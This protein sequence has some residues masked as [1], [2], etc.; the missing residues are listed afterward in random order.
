MINYW[1]PFKLGNAAI[2]NNGLPISLDELMT[3]RIGRC[4]IKLLFKLGFIH[5]NESSAENKL[6]GCT[7]DIISMEIDMDSPTIINPDDANVM[8]VVE[9]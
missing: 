4:G 6:Y 7:Y 9:I 2:N 1:I 5:F 3:R 8:L